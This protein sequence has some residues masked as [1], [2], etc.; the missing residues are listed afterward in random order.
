[1][2][3]DV[4]R[5]AR[6]WF[7][8]TTHPTKGS[9]GYASRDDYNYPPQVPTA[10]GLVAQLAEGYAPNAKR[11]KTTKTWLEKDARRLTQLQMDARID[12]DY[13]LFLALLYDLT[14]QE[15]RSTTTWLRKALL[16][17]QQ[18]VSSLLQSD[19]SLSASLQ[20]QYRNQP[21]DVEN[22]AIALLLQMLQ[23]PKQG[24]K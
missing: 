20:S 10:A 1:M 8:Q 4:L 9:I 11:L 2:R 17:V 15:D 6:N 3:R 16:Q 19:G 21:S 22:T 7:K 14:P 18:N 12:L 23:Q 24:N 5:D 13:W